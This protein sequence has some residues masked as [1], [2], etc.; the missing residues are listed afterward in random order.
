M[1]R[2]P[3]WHAYYFDRRMWR[4]TPGQQA[5]AATA[6]LATAAGV[7]WAVLIHALGGAR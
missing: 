5:A 3:G 6:A 2:P 1:S 4:P 7:T